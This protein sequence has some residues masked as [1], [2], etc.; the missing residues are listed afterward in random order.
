MLNW[1]IAASA[2]K[3]F[4]HVKSVV[5]TNYSNPSCHGG[6]VAAEI[7][8]DPALRAAWVTELDGM[9]QRIKNLRSGLVNGLKERG[10]KQDFSFI[11]RQRGMFS[12]SGLNDQQVAWLKD[13]KGIYV[14]KGGR[15]NVAGIRADNLA[16]V[17]DSM[18]EMLK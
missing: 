7:L 3:A 14:V 13:Q 2:E 8:G 4:S 5:R 18:A 12:F 10:V 17:C 16:Y 9:R 1:Q 15:M 11:E 6:A